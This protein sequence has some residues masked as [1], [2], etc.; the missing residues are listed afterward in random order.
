VMPILMNAVI[1]PGPPTVGSI[2]WILPFSPASGWPEGIEIMRNKLSRKA[3]TLIELLVV[4]S[5][6]ALLL[7]FLLPA[8]G[9]ARLQARSSLCKN[10]IRQLALANLTYAAEN[11]DQLVLGA[12]DIFGANLQRWHGR[13]ETHNQPFDSTRGPLARYLDDGQVKQ[14]PAPFHHNQPA[15]MDF[16]DGCGGYGY[17]QTYLGSRIWQAGFAACSQSTRYT[18]IRR[19]ASTL[20]FAD[21]AMARLEGSVP[22]YLEYSFAEPPF[23]VSSGQPQPQWGY[24][25]PSIHFRHSG[26]ANVAWSDGHVDGQAMVP[27]AGV[28]VYG[29]KSALM[30]LGWFGPLNNSFFDLW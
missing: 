2:N 18:E 14:C 6:I 7:T 1:S 24:A 9:Q 3:F 21:T 13:R 10:N 30:N 15:S 27:F 4:L 22:Y 5:I 28:N 16:E 29:V 19:C 17:N 11:G 20:M 12:A 26:R 25:S 23:F 8:L